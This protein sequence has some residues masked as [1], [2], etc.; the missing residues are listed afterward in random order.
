MLHHYQTPRIVKALAFATLLVATG[1]AAQEV[2]TSVIRPAYEC[3]M[4]CHDEA[5]LLWESY[6]FMGD[7]DIA[8]QVAH[9]DYMDCVG[10]C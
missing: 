6:V 5:L 3:S 2:D 7:A 1:L 9:D 4:D 8:D 10:D